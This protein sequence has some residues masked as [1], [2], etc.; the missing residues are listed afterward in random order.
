[1]ASDQIVAGG[2]RS[3]SRRVQGHFIRAWVFV[4]LICLG[5][6]LAASPGTAAPY[7]NC[8]PDEFHFGF[9][10][11]VTAAEDVERWHASRLADGNVAAAGA[12]WRGH[13]RRHA[14]EVLKFL[15]KPAPGGDEFSALKREVEAALRP[16]AILA[17]LKE[18]DYKWGAW[19]AHLRPHSDLVPTLLTALKD[20][21]DDLPETLLAL[22]S[23]RDPRVLDPVLAH[24]NGNDYRAAGDAAL[25]L[26]YFGG[27]KVELALI[28]ALAHD[29]GWRQVRACG[30]LARI[31]TPKALP[32]L[33][34][35]ANY[36]GYT[37]AL[38]ITGMARVA[39]VQIER[40]HL[41]RDPARW[42]AGPPP[43]PAKTLRGHEGPVHG[44]AFSPDGRLL[45]SVGDDEQGRVW[46]PVTGKLVATFPGPGH[47]WAMVTFVG[48]GRVAAA[49]RP[50][51]G[52]IRLYDARTGGEPL[53]IPVDEASVSSVTASADGHR[54][55][56]SGYAP[57]C[58]EAVRVFEVKTLAE[59]TTLPKAKRALAFSPDGKTL[60]TLGRSDPHDIEL[61]DLATAKVV[62]TLR[63]HSESVLSA[64]FPPDGRALATGGDWTVRVWDLATGKETARF[65]GD[66]DVTGVAFS[67][68]GRRVAAAE[69]DGVVRIWDV[70]SGKAVTVLPGRSPVAYSPDGRLLATADADGTA[71]LLWKLDGGDEPRK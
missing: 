6:N 61:W 7:T 64:G 58:Q 43:K 36:S 21:S 1:M 17:E 53:A 13:S 16:A 32:A 60:A 24:L 55:A 27:P 45:A 51:D 8:V 22:G 69:A 71:L 42:P 18:G 67:P 28:N 26:G 63:G 19:L 44:I 11:T 47:H 4:G 54:I 23:S 14:A 46:D 50:D 15:D 20:R 70:A 68:D 2:R 30:A 12:L 9:W 10:H 48:P 52:S 41:P 38:N 5:L 31:G 57:D 66:S 37:G 62:A 65:R 49:G 56:G 40:R 3:V 34:K 25:A 29:N 39:V 59:V 35:L 33:E